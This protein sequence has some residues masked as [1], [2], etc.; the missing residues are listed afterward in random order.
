[1]KDKTGKIL[2]I[3]KAKNLKS[4][5]SSYF[6]NSE[7]LLPKTKI[8]I[9]LV[10]KID[11]IK[12]QSELEALLLEAN[13]IKKYNPKYN[14][15]LKDGKSYP[16]LEITLGEDFPRVFISRK[17]G[18]SKSKYF[19][20]YP[21]AKTLKLILKYVRKIFP[22]CSCKSHPSSCLYHHLGLCP[23]PIHK[24]DKK[25]YRKIIKKIITFLQG[26]KNILVKDL[27]KEMDSCSQEQNYEQASIIKNQLLK[28]E[29]LGNLK[30]SP[31]SYLEN[32]NLLS[33]I[34]REELTDLKNV[35]SLKTLPKR[36]ECYDIS[37]TS[38]TLA[39][40]SMVVFK[41]GEADKKEYR[42]FK[43]K[44]SQTP[45]DLL[46]LSEV[47]E[48]RF[49]NNWPLP[50]LII[51]DGGK[52]QLTVLERLQE[53]HKL[54]IPSISLAKKFEEI[55][56]KQEKIILP[57]SSPALFLLQKIRDEAHR[58]ARSY[59]LYLR[60]KNLFSAHHKDLSH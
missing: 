52:T 22:F 40:G 13:L 39:T 27:K 21:D 59:H 46:M 43:I 25:S 37:N 2:Y 57:A 7:N 19:G 9:S 44:N 16:Y 5:V 53:R 54:K 35:L 3:G 33:D 60:S 38:G 41:N 49:N 55:Y 14:V 42:R 31:L 47:F 36:I 50:D 34:I 18:N 23:L 6:Q 1:M 30:I 58:F 15:D 56:V 8:L 28:I 26:K 51:V 24:I 10:L 4:R 45:N 32:P 29:E 11:Y 20:P 17:T 12:V 48:R